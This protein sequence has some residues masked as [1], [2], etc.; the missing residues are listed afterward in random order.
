MH[1]SKMTELRLRIYPGTQALA[2]LSSMTSCISS[3]IFPSLLV[4]TKKRR[5][6]ANRYK[7]DNFFLTCDPLKVKKELSPGQVRI[8][9]VHPRAKLVSDGIKF[10]L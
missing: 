2:T 7:G 4:L 10:G 5:N 1:R 3:V 9:K 6:P 8:M